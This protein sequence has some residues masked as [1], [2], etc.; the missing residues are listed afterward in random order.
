MFLAPREPEELYFSPDDP[1][2]IHNAIGTPGLGALHAKLAAVMDQWQEETHDSAPE[3][4]T[5]DHFDRVTGYLD[6]ATGRPVHELRQ[7]QYRTA[8][9]SDRNAS[10]I[11]APG[12]R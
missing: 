2:Q 9:G 11:D 5:P 10:T 7:P 4:Y 8:P 1:W 3:D 12:P 6:Q